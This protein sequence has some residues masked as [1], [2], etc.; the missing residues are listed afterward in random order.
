MDTERIGF[1]RVFT[2]KDGVALGH[3]GL[4]YASGGLKT[5]GL[6]TLIIKFPN[7]VELSLAINSTDEGAKR[8]INTIVQTA[9]NGAWVND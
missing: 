4:L 6:R 2:V 1:N 9:Y 8:D 3:G 7:N 5:P